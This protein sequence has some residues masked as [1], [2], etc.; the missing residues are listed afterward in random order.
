MS[1]MGLVVNDYPAMLSQ[2]NRD[3]GEGIGVNMR[4]VAAKIGA[5]VAVRPKFCHGENRNLEMFR[6]INRFQAICA[7]QAQLQA[8]FCRNSLGFGFETTFHFTLIPWRV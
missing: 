4:K 6:E 2:E 8:H 7:S 5:P 1:M 3:S